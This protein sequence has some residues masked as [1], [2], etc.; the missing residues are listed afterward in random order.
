MVNF[1]SPWLPL[2][3]DSPNSLNSTSK[4]LLNWFFFLY[5]HWYTE[6]GPAILN[7]IK[8]SMPPFFKP[9]CRL[10]LQRMP[11]SASTPLSVLPMPPT[12]HFILSSSVTFLWI[13]PDSWFALEGV[14]WNYI[15]IIALN[16]L[17]C[18]TF[19]TDSK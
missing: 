9:L 1:F 7:C 8:F 18:S 10:F 6:D 19:W 11:L 16:T 4:C 2:F 12:Y 5:S 15:S 13:C 3:N 14:T 17:Y